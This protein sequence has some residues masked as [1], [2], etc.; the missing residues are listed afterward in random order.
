MTLP[1]SGYLQLGTDGATG[2]SIN[3]EFGYGNDLASY[4]GVYFGRGGQLFRF[5]VP[6]NSIDMNAF[7]STARISSGNTYIG[8]GYWTVPVYN[9]IYAQ[10]Q[11]GSGG[12]AGAWGY[13]GCPG[14]GFTGSNSGGPGNTSSWGGYLAAGGGGGGGGNGGGGAPGAVASGSWTNPVQGGGGPTSGNQIYVT[15]GTG[16]GGGSGGSNCTPVSYWPY[17][18]CGGGS[19]GNTGADGYVYSSWS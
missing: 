6:G 17:C 13:N 15:V 3:S 1:A 18:V 12:N 19:G 14:G 7:Y 8:T 10:V 5:P 16:G 9:S 2:R 4:L 11:G